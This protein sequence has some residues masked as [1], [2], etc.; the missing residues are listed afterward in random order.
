MTAPTISPLPTPKPRLGRIMLIVFMIMIVTCGGGCGA[1]WAWYTQPVRDANAAFDHLGTPPVPQPTE[2]REDTGNV[3]CVDVC[4]TYT[5]SWS[6]RTDDPDAI[7]T[8]VM[9]WAQT[10][11]PI[12]AYADRPGFTP[13]TQC[14]NLDRS[15]GPTVRIDKCAMTVTVNGQPTKVSVD[16]YYNGVDDPN[17]RYDIEAVINIPERH[18]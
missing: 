15:D 12:S 5:R 7:V 3:I 14:P 18:L 10:A 13:W 11:G 2:K 4:A 6:G 9:G 16:F 1:V 17:P 8:A